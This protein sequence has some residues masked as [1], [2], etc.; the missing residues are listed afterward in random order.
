MIILTIQNIKKSCREAKNVGPIFLHFGLI[1]EPPGIHYDLVLY[2]VDATLVVSEVDLPV[3]DGDEVRGCEDA[4]DNV[5]D[6]FACSTSSVPIERRCNR[7]VLC[8]ARVFKA[9]V[10]TTSLLSLVSTG[11]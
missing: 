8:I 5:P 10:L 3:V 7:C 11:S 1:D 9:F 4:V 6:W 2:G